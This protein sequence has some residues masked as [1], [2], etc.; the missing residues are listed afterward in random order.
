MQGSNNNFCS[1]MNCGLD[2]LGASL[3]ARDRCCRKKILRGSSS[4]IDSRRAS[5]AQDRFKNPACAI[6]LLRVVRVAPTFS[7]ASV[8]SGKV[9]LEQILSGVR[10]IADVAST[11]IDV[12]FGPGAAAVASSRRMSASAQ[13]RRWRLAVVTNVGT[14]LYFRRRVLLGG[15]EHVAC[16]LAAFSRPDDLNDVLAGARRERCASAAR[17]RSQIARSTIRAALSRRQIRRGD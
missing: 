6:L 13:R 16:D 12:A 7:T 3:S 14:L 1:R 17:R 2:L 8:T 15:K 10:S 11:W 9:R 4:N 5:N